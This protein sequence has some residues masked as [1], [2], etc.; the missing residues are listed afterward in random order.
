[1]HIM[2]TQKGQ[3]KVHFY[4]PILMIFQKKIEMMLKHTHFSISKFIPP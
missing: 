2:F 1:M 3:M 4:N